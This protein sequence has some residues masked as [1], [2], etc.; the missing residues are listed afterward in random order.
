MK[1]RLAFTLALLLP[2][3]NC[4][5]ANT[6]ATGTETS[7]IGTENDSVSKRIESK[8]LRVFFEQNFAWRLSQSPQMQT[9][10]GHKVD[11]GKWDDISQEQKARKYEHWKQDLRALQEF[12]VGKLD[13]QAQISYR[14]FEF[15]HKTKI[16]GYEWRLHNYPINQMHGMQA[17]VPAFLINYHKIS[18]VSDAEAYV[19]RLQGVARLFEQL[20]LGLIARQEL[21]ILPPK[22]VYAHVLRDCEN[23]LKGKPF[24]NGDDSVLLGDF[25][26]KVDALKLS[27]EDSSA[28]LA[29][30]ES[31]LLSSVKPAYTG[32]LALLKVQEKVAKTDDGVWRLPKGDE[33]Y[34][35]ALRRMTT[36]DKTPAEVHELGL[37]EVARIHG[38]MKEIM[39]VTKFTGDLQAFFEFMRT[40]KQ[41][42]LPN[43][44]AGRAEYLAQAVAI[45][46]V[47]R[48]KLDQLFITKPKAGII[49][50]RVEAFREQSAGKA[51]YSGPSPDGSR[52]GTYYANL[53][54]MERMPTY[55]MEALAY[56]EGIPGHHMQV[57]IATE[58][59]SLP[60]FRRHG[61]YTAYGEGWGLYSEYLAKEVGLYADPY[62]D[63]G[64]LAMELWR[65]CRL[66]VDTGIHDKK[67]SRQDAIDYLKANTPNPMG[68]VV[69][70][71]ERYIVMPSQATA[72][73]IGMI[74]ILRLRES[75]KMKLGQAFD[76]REFH[77]V[78]IA[79]GPVPLA[80]LADLVDTYI[81]D[82][83]ATK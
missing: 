60:D 13:A 42:Y 39:K 10:L 29:K 72:Y 36:T 7:G 65:A 53:Y 23:I 48:S 43:T 5:G 52:P 20:Q 71:I 62:S 27:T 61:G 19:S 31:A 63:F 40:D 66:V 78:I 57:A 18:S 50:K 45:I 64:R 56:H 9:R 12:T 17:E 55:Q 25:R 1:S 79:N 68:D 67:W 15:D 30:A 34:R 70:A 6:K 82:K 33:F 41:F 32:L 76:I 16:E 80:V 54:R 81:A 59:T 58:L 49:V 47:M 2:L 28:L 4:G 22:F 69:N 75:A 83:M 24:T 26:K 8:R 38:E 11:Y 37:S 77:E 51:F 3:S 73:K 74:E 46:D 44:E 35:F 14:L 21:G